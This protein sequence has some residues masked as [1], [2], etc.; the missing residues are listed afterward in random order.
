MSNPVEVGGH[1][2]PPLQG[3]D[4]GGLPER[5]RVICLHGFP[6]GPETFAPLRA[7]LEAQR[8]QTFAPR[9][10]GHQSVDAR[11]FLE[12]VRDKG[13]IAAALAALAE[14]SAPF[15]APP[16]PVHLIGHDWGAVLGYALVSQRARD[17]A[18]HLDARVSRF[19]RRI[20]TFAA[21]AIPPLVAPLTSALQHPRALT[22][23]DYLASFQLPLVPERL[24]ASPAFLAALTRRWSPGFTLPVEVTA[25]VTRRYRDP[26]VRRAVLAYYRALVPRL[27]RPH[28]ALA[29]WRLLMSPPSIPTLVIRG[30]RDGCFVPEVFPDTVAK[31]SLHAEVELVTTSSGHFP[32]LEATAAVAEAWLARHAG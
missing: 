3:C 27:T 9:L 21:L 5:P 13:A 7:M 4:R 30:D 23:F 26:A 28:E 16:G 15:L 2:G 12:A 25:D 8:V 11:D 6:D 22:R 29:T 24:I 1:G 31:A 10:P 19:S 14:I 32:Q 17:D 20:S 18:G